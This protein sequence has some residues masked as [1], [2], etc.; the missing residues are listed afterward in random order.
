MSHGHGEKLGR[1]K[2][3]LIASLLTEAT[4][5]AAARKTGVSVRSVKTWMR[6]PS[7][8]RAYREAR[9]AVLERTTALLL[10]MT[11]KAVV[12]L[13]EAMDEE[14]AAIRLR[15]ATTVLSY[16]NE[17]IAKVDLAEDLAELRRQVEETQ[18]AHHTS[19]TRSGATP[20]GHCG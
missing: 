8:R 19:Q 17:T 5:E 6:E 15:A 1:K 11:S 9:Q 16:V 4:L 12:K 18:R 7:F 3:L 14:D 10:A 2:E 20:N 13:Y